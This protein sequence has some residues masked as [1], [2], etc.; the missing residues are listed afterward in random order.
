MEPRRRAAAGL[1]GAA[2]VLIGIGMVAVVF[3]AGFVGDGGATA[4]RSGTTLVGPS[5]FAASGSPVAS[6]SATPVIGSPGAASPS[7]SASPQTSAA[8]S[9]RSPGFAQQGD[10]FAYYAADGSVIP[11]KPIAGLEVRIDSGKAIYYALASNRYG[12]KTDSWAGE[13]MPLVTMGQPDGSSAVTGGVVLDGHVVSRLIA[14]NL[15]AITTDGDKWIVALPVDIRSTA[16]STVQVTFDQFGLAGWSDTPR[17]IVR[18]LGSQPIVEMNPSN[19]GFHVLVEALGITS[20]QVI[21]PVRLTLA[22]GA[23]DPAHAMNEL[24]LY[25]NGTTDVTHDVLVDGAVPV[26]QPMLKATSD[27]CVSLVVDGSRADLGP[28]KI[29]T[30]GDVP[31][32]VASN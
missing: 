30:V 6:R 12:L 24:L 21:D 31:V 15:A 2:V 1:T 26:G 8:P 19:G 25:G 32:F 18:F 29:L 10:G 28:D 17:V 23:I 11:V 13:F 27:V 3:D 20:W 22:P 16:G 9:P 14:D 4:G 7:S 5:S